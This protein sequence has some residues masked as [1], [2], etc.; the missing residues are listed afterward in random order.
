MAPAQRI[1]N[2]VD[3][4]RISNLADQTSNAYSYGRYRSWRSVVQALV[5]RG[6]TDVEIEAI[7]RSKWTR[8]AADASDRRYGAATGSDLTRFMDKSA[9]IAYAVRRLLRGRRPMRRHYSTIVELAADIADRMQMDSGNVR[10]SLEAH[11][12]SWARYEDLT[13]DDVDDLCRVVWADL[14]GDGYP[15]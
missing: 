2:L 13:E 5:R 15:W 12:Q 10:C 4:Q 11:R 9:D 6:Y 3:Q 8:W 1:S 14:I 7:V